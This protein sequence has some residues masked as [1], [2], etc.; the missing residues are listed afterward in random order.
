MPKVMVAGASGSLGLEVIKKL[1]QKGVPLRAL[2]R[3]QE[4]AEMLRP[5]TDDVVIAD[6]TNAAELQGV[7]EDIEVLFSAVG[8]SV[9]LFT[10]GESFEKI[11]Y[12]VNENLINAAVAAGVRRIVY[13]SIKGADA[14]SG[15][16]LADVHKRVE[17]LLKLR[18]INHTVIRPVGLFSGLNDL[19][20]MGKQGAIPIP[21]SG[22]HKT[23]PIHQEDLAQV[24]VD[25]MFEGPQ[26]LEAG[27]PEVFT[28]NQIAQ[29]VYE[30]TGGRIMHIP[31]MLIEPGLL[32]IKY[33][34]EN[35]KDKLEFFKYV[36][37]NDMVAPQYGKI[38]FMDYLKNLDLNQL[39]DVW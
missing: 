31:E 19:V 24:V 1:R 6:A 27:G 23:N 18:N 12:G 5:Y 3:S 7:F 22:K 20:I 2:D 32:F 13:V 9:S 11:D 15:L 33:V 25:V 26:V 8:Q 39:P 37:T 14:A 28:R 10:K 30:K 29:M 36:S 16:T 4:K 35:I 34:D 21:G 17:D 38:T